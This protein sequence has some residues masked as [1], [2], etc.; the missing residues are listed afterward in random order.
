MKQFFFAFIYL[1]V[2]FNI[3]A[4]NYSSMRYKEG[5]EFIKINKSIKD[6]PTVLEFFSFY[7][8]H[9]Y[10]FDYIYNISK[11]I[12]ENLPK[13]IIME[14][15]HVNFLGALGNE[16]TKAWTVAKI[17]SIEEKVIPLLFEGIQKTESINTPNDIKN[18]FVKLGIK[19]KEYDILINSLLV[20]SLLIKQQK[21]AKDFQLIGV[22]AIFVHGK[23]MLCNHN[24]KATKE[25][26]Y[27]QIYSEII[28]FLIKNRD[29]F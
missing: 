5:I 25:Y 21:A 23:Y 24:I 4:T 18:I 16:L 9:C 26:N 13:N 6:A 1:L 20:N 3:F 12:K 22:P 27:P 8:P 14:R 11:K 15:Y 2:S 7:C 19:S 10:E 17:F 28:N 29:L